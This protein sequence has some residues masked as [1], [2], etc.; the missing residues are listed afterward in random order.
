M[1]YRV[2]FIIIIMIL[3]GGLD[4]YKELNDLAIV[5]AISIDKDENDMYIVSAQI[6]N[7]KK[8]FSGTKSEGSGS[9]IT[10]YESKAKTI[11]EALRNMTG[12]SPKKLYISHMRVL[13]IDEKVAKEGISA[14][15]DFFL[16]DI[17]S[18]KEVLIVVTSEGTKASKLIKV[19]TPIETNPTKNLEDSIY[20]TFEYRGSTVKSL[21]NETISD[22]IENGIELVLPS[23][24]LEGNAEK[25]ES[26]DNI[27]NVTQVAKVLVGEIAYFNKDKL[28]GYLSKEDSISHNMMLNKIK[29]TIIET[30]IN[31]IKSAIQIIGFES[32]VKPKF[33]N[34]NFEV[35][36]EVNSNAGIAELSEK[37]NISNQ[38]DIENIEIQIEKE[39]KK[40]LENYIDNVKNKYHSDIIGFGRMFNKYLNKEY[41][42]VKDVFY[43]KYFKNIKC[44]INVKVSLENEGGM[45]KQW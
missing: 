42:K 15:M 44:N 2:L 35:D 11:Q 21:L 33:I 12:E 24:K 32:S 23:V 29:N 25:G 8:E 39:I 6:L 20:S 4:N 45:V 22:L 19:L 27:D 5:S 16:R 31:D 38:K 26:K 14:T 41:T 1:K 37:L 13:L 40:R 34:N 36:I 3:T 10:V 30:N 28:I 18:N 9:N 43:E 7:S 17:K